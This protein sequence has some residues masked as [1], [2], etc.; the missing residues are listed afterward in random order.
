MIYIFVFVFLISGIYVFLRQPARSVDRSIEDNKASYIKIMDKLEGKNN[1]EKSKYINL[2]KSK[3]DNA[4]SKMLKAADEY[5]VGAMSQTDYVNHVI[6]LSDTLNKK[7]VIDIISSNQEYILQ[8]KSQRYYLYQNGWIDLFQNS[9]ID[10]ILL[11]L[12]LLSITPIFCKEYETDMYVINR[13]SSGGNRYMYRTKIFAGIVMAITMS[14]ILCVENILID[15]FRFGL[16]GITYPIQSIHIFS[17]YPWRMNILGMLIL[18]ILVSILAAI[19]L[20]VIIM[21]LSVITKKVVNTILITISV[22]FIPLFIMKEKVIYQLPLPTGLL[23]KQGYITGVYNTNLGK[24]DFFDIKELMTNFIIVTIICS[25]LIILGRFFYNYS[26]KVKLFMMQKIVVF[27]LTITLIFTGCGKKENRTED[28]FNNIGWGNVFV[29]EKDVIDATGDNIVV[30]RDKEEKNLIRNPFLL[31]EQKNMI[32]NGVCGN[33]AYIT[34]IYE[35]GDYDILSIDLDNYEEKTVYEH[36][37]N[38]PNGYN[39]LGIRKE[40]LSSYEIQKQE[41]IS[42]CFATADKLYILIDESMYE[43]DIETKKRCP[44]ADDVDSNIVSYKDGKIYYIN[45]GYNLAC[46]TINTR[47]S[48]VIDNGLI[49]YIYALSDSLLIQYTSKD[50]YSM[51]YETGKT[52]KICDVTGDI[53]NANNNYIYCCDTPQK[54]NVFDIKSGKLVNAIKTDKDICEV[55]STSDGG[56]IY[57]V[58]VKDNKFFLEKH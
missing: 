39:Y 43:I 28:I 22:V 8:D 25:M 51:N 56:S 40:E 53:M 58:T 1:E 2:L 19:Y 24:N 18:Y 44:I 21:S 41:N 7:K 50:I 3:M 23:N 36:H 34:R 15:Y 26:G 5:E 29:Y 37:V 30:K 13:I 42:A 27:L 46:Y 38:L 10:I 9:G 45:K 52:S 14:A 4:E 54:L 55:K 17:N 12:I 20:S 48:E 47:K 57:I 6:E 33:V 35:T 49:S 11:F 31:K 32:V 16:K